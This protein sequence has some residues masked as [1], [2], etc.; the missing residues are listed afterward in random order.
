MART[1]TCP[2]CSSIGHPGDYCAECGELIPGQ[3][4]IP[5]AKYA[6]GAANS[7]R[8]FQEDELR[9]RR[10]P[11]MTMTPNRPFEALC[12]VFCIAGDEAGMG[13]RALASVAMRVTG[14]D[15]QQQGDP[16]AAFSLAAQ[17]L[18]AKAQ[19]V[20][21]DAVVGCRFDYRVAAT[22]G[23]GGLGIGAGH[24]AIEFFAYG[25]A[26]RWVK[27][28]DGEEPER[29]GPSTPEPAPKVLVRRN[30]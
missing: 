17:L 8:S 24:Q 30:D 10:I 13:A 2:G 6:A 28:M 14:V 19:E 1:A 22:A 25:T 20:G 15:F 16:E 9:Q 7:A 3:A 18:W 4:R 21:A 23:L 5:E 12:P 11:V 29:A 26:V 27:D